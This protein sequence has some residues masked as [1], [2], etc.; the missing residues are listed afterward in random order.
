MITTIVKHRPRLPC[1]GS[2]VGLKERI[3]TVLQREGITQRELSRRA[4]LTPVHVNQILRRLA[5]DPEASVETATLHKIADGGKVSRAWLVSGVGTPDDAEAPPRP[6][7]RPPFGQMPEWPELL[8][9][10]KEI[11][12]DVAPWVWVRLAELQPQLEADP[13]PIMIAEL[14]KWVQRHERLMRPPVKG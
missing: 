14:A 3:E 6:T 11:E 2:L 10:A 4:K 1:D 8:A 9:R 7:W 13:T 12:P 5:Q